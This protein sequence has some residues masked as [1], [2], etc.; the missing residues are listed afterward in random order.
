MRSEV[1]SN[2]ARYDGIRYGTDRSYFADE[3]KQRVML[4]TYALSS[5]YYDQ[6]YNKAMRVRTLIIEDFKKAFQNVDVIIGPT[7][8]DH[9]SSCRSK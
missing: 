4:G 9:S 7:S 2:L 1:S 3:A 6:Y 5:G 8:S